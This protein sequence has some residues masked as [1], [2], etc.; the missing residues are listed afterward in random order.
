[1]VVVYMTK[2]SGRAE[3]IFKLFFSELIG[4]PYAVTTSLDEFLSYSGP[5]INYSKSR[6]ASGLYI[7]SGV[8]L[9]EKG[10]Q[11]REIAVGKYD[12]VPICFLNDDPNS[13]LPFDPFEA[14]F[15]LVTRYE[16]YLA[17]GKDRAGRYK[18]SNSI[19]SKGDFLKIPVVNL[20]AD[21]VLQLLLNSFPHLKVPVKKFRF[22]PS[23]DIDHAY[24]YGHR[25]LFRTIGGYLCDFKN[26]RLDLMERRTRVIMGNRK[27]PYDTFELMNSIHQEFDVRPLF[28]ILFADY[29]GND[30]NVSVKDKGFHA[31]IKQLDKDGEVGVHP[32]LISSRD[33]SYLEDE[34]FGLSKILGRDILIARQ[35]F[36]K[37][38]FPWTYRNL[39]NLGITDDY[40]MGYASS[41]GFRAGIADSYPFFDL[42]TDEETSLRIHPACLMDVSLRDYLDLSREQGFSEIKEIIN[43][44]KAVNGELITLWH[45]ESF[46]DEGRWEGWVDVYRDMF[47]YATT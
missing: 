47:K 38:T 19:V 6:Q 26:A 43:S 45:N 23:I 17:L 27:D 37:I 29:G 32:S 42:I 12:G 36:L 1:M 35:H 9:F 16:E 15:F 3:Y 39:I 2:P 7:R 34:V 5:K 30:N 21:M 33:F 14:A 10:Y 20:W 28:F 18:A 13:S 31:L 40:S 44:V 8:I 4:L 11:H 25:P 22:T 41:P 24:A 46:T